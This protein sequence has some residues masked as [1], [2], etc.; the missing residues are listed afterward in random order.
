MI[1]GNGLRI[2]FS[3]FLIF[4]FSL[5]TAASQ[6]YPPGTFSVD[7]YPI[8]CGMNTFILNPMLPDVGINTG[9]GIIYLNPVM[10]NNLP[11]VLKLYWV[12][13]ECGHTAVGMSEPGADCWAVRTGRDQGWFPPSAFQAL[14]QMFANNPG[15]MAH[16]SGP[17]RVQNMWNCYNAP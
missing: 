14:A 16:G 6:T 11:T 7:G 17:W 13:H 12:G 8:V 4:F 2:L 15:D 9:Q 5:K 10:L 1:E 3:T